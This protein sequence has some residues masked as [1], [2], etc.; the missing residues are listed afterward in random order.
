MSEAN[1]QILL[2]FKK[3]SLELI[4]QL[5]E[6]LEDID[7]DFTKVQELEKFGQRVDRIMGGAKMIALEKDASHITHQ[8]GTYTEICKTVAYKA[9]QITD[10]ENLFAVS[11]AFLTDATEALSAMV[12]SIDSDE[13]LDIETL[14][15]HA[16]LDRLR[17]IS[18]KFEIGLRGSASF[19]T[20]NAEE[21]MDQNAIDLLLQKMGL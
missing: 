8:I 6:I 12:N 18:G 10:N 17:W 20:G 16:F 1:T 21:A 14:F 19:D 11:V 2:G 4:R 13:I 5:F 3:E 9:S 15:N 7:D